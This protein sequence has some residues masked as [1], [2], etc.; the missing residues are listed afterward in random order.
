MKKSSVYCNRI[1]YFL[2]NTSSVSESII[3][4]CFCVSGT[5]LVAAKE[6]GRHWIGIDQSG[7]AIEVAQKRIDK[8]T[9]DMFTSGYELLSSKELYKSKTKEKQHDHKPGAFHDRACAG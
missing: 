9:N 8:T 2:I 1:N 4:D 5:T 7:R 3:L 6:L